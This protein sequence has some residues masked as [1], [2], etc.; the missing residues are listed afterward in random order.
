MKSTEAQSLKPLTMPSP[1]AGDDPAIEQPT[2]TVVSADGVNFSTGIPAPYSSPGKYIRRNQMNGIFNALSRDA[3][4]GQIGGFYTFNSDVANAIGGYPSGAVLK[5]MHMGILYDVIS[6]VDDN[7]YD[8][9]E[10]GVDNI[11]WRIISPGSSATPDWNNKNTLTTINSLPESLGKLGGLLVMPFDGYLKLNELSLSG[12]IPNTTLTIVYGFNSLQQPLQA[13]IP[14]V[15]ADAIS[16][17]QFRICAVIAGSSVTS[18][19]LSNN[20]PTAG[21]MFTLASAGSSNLSDQPI[22]VPKGYKIQLF[23][24]QNYTTEWTTEYG[25]YE[26]GQQTT[27]TVKMAGEFSC[28]FNL[29]AY[30]IIG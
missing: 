28:V 18:I 29:D 7:K 11:H 1:F 6:L 17:S 30:P 27:G 14:I 9:V 23:G 13:Y 3:F 8:F 16:M 4:Q 26:N 22:A 19:N 5:Y 15:C 21:T 2:Q 25:R 12:K 20:I 10:N 24:F